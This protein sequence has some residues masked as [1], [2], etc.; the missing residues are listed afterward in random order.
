MG[1]E[2]DFQTDAVVAE[3]QERAG[4]LEDL[5]AGPY[6][7][8]LDRFVDSLNADAKLNDVGRYMAKDRMLLHTVNRLNYV[9]DRKRY[10]GIAEV[11]IEKPVFIIGLPRTG[12]TILHDILD[13]DPA[14]RAPLT[15]ELMFPSP[16][17]TTE[18]A[19]TDPRIAACQAR[20]RPATA[21]PS[22][23]R[24]CIRPARCCRRSA[25]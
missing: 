7:E 23:S 21:S 18:E 2:Q 10:P 11:A 9:E 16:P 20:S 6:L 1:E 12:T 22:S 5:G 14:N 8:G 17:P 4:G 19:A 25:W 3:A 13:Q 15:W 24:P